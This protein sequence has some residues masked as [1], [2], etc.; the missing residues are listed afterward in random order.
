MRGVRRLWWPLAALFLLLCTTSGYAQT[1]SATTGAING[2]VVDNTGAVLPGVTVTIASSSMMGTRTAVTNQ[3]GQYRFPAIPPGDYLLT[4]ELAGFSMV[5][6][7]GIRVGLGFTA[8]VNVELGVASLEESVTV[9]GASPV[10]DTSATNVTTNFQAEQLA[11]LP[12]ARDLWAILSAAPAISLT[13]IDVGGSAAGTQTGYFA[14]GTTGQNRPMV[15]GIVAT[16]GTGAAGFY[17]DYGSFDEVSVGTAAHGAEMPWPGVQ[18]QFISKS[19]GNDYTGMFYADYQNE[20]IQSFN[21]D[22]DQIARGF[23][24]GGGLD[25]QD[26]N[27]LASYHDVN[28]DI[29]GYVR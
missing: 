7:E 10:V 15:E 8:T 2:R 28:A 25:P 17:Y 13:R 18:S 3:D 12:N 20:S 4:Y 29:G 11:D 1:V 14:Y 6:R 22:E 24:G 27:R 19:G 9:T 23:Q 26:I 21:I 5:K 16:E